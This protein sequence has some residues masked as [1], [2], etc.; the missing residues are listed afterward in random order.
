MYCRFLMRVYL[1]HKAWIL[2][3]QHVVDA[4][5]VRADYQEHQEHPASQRHQYH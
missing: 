1:F 2:Q 3:V 5:R 4:G